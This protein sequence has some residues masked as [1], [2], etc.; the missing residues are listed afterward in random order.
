[1]DTLTITQFLEMKDE[2]QKKIEEIIKELYENTGYLIQFI[3]VDGRIGVKNIIL[4]TDMMGKH[5]P[6]EIVIG[7]TKNTK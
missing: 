2:A 7:T 6:R 1:M 3:K 5:F 4:K